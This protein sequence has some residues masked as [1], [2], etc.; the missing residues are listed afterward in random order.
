MLAQVL[1]SDF[2]VEVDFMSIIIS[3]DKT[4]VGCKERI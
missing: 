4:L 2:Y 3:Y 1:I